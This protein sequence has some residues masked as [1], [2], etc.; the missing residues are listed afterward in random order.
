MN[1]FRIPLRGAINFNFVAATIWNVRNARY[2]CVCIGKKRTSLCPLLQGL[3][4]STKQ[5]LFANREGGETR[6]EFARTSEKE[7]WSDFR[8]NRL[9]FFLSSMSRD[10][11]FSFAFRFLQPFV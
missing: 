8:E 9:A 10:R 4:V 1:Y 7:S 11:A 5:A 2:L 6:R 3:P